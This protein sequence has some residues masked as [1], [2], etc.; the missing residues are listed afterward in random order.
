MEPKLRVPVIDYDLSGGIRDVAGLGECDKAHVVV[1]HRGVPLC[2]FEEAVTGG[3]LDGMN[4]WA[5]VCADPHA[6]AV[7]KI[8]EEALDALYA[9]SNEIPSRLPPCSIVIGTR[10]RP[11]DV[12]RCLSALVPSI[13]DDVEVMLIDNDPST[14]ATRDI[15]MRYPVRY[16]RQWRRGVNWARA[17]GVQLSRHDVVLYVDDDVVVDPKWVDEMR[18]PFADEHVGAVAGAVEP[19]QLDT[20]GQYQHELYSSFY[21]GFRRK[22]HSLLTC[23]PASAGHIGAGASMGVRRSLALRYKIFEAELDGGTAAKSGGDVFGLYRILTAGYSIV[24]AP[25]ALAWHRH[26][27][28]Y[29]DLE[30]MLYGYSVGGYCVLLRALLCDRDPDALLIGLRWFFEYHLA[31]LWKTLRNKPGARPLP[32]IGAEIRGAL[33][34]PAAYWKARRRERMLGPL[35]DTILEQA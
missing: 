33:S 18:R 28:T 30:R 34:A 21:R 15:A 4:V 16:V 22:V 5:R 12:E 24:Y 19:F 29:E 2:R 10:D 23:T 26:R 20:Y 32:L 13:G 35:D 14:N 6:E 8:A 17:R 9:A 11:A 7:S 27:T 3:V 31:E 1:R 25:R